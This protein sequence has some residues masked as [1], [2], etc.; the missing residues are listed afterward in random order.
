MCLL[1]KAGTSITCGYVHGSLAKIMIFHPV[2]LLITAP[3]PS[4]LPFYT[5]MNFWKNSGYIHTIQCQLM[6][7]SIRTLRPLPKNSRTALLPRGKGMREQYKEYLL[8]NNIINKIKNCI[9]ENNTRP[10]LFF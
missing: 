3:K 2:R 7:H 5:G 8:H 1:F 10:S 6:L 4:L 9:S